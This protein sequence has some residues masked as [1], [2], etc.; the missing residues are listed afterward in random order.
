MANALFGLRVWMAFITL[1]NL[2]I[3]ITFYA[4]LVPY[5]NKN[6]SEMS[7]HYEYS[8]DDYAFIITSPILFLAYLYSIWG[9]PRLHK[10]L[11]AFLMLL[12][13]LFLMGPMLRQIHLQIENAKKF[14]Q[15]TPSEM[16]FEPFRCYGDTIDPACFVF[17]A[18][19]FIPVIVGF[20]VLIE[21]F[22]TLLRGPLHP[23][24]KVD[25]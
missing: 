12:P 24:K 18:Y 15:Y 6:K 3:I 9:Q 17:R 20:F 23:T 2:S 1:V 5:F 19:T 10:Y 14:N 16:E 22:V 4:W 11:R 21:V 8:W 7:D 13:A 25:F